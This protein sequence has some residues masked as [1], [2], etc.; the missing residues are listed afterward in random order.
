LKNVRSDTEAP[1][2]NVAG[3]LLIAVPSVVAAGLVI[4]AIPYYAGASTRIAS[5]Y[6]NVAGPADKALSP[7]INGYTFHRHHKLAAAKLDLS[8]EAKTEASF[9]Q[10]LAQITFPAAADPHADLLIAADKK[11][12]KLIGLQMQARTLRKLRSFDARDQAADVA[13]EVQV[14]I[15]RQDLGLPAASGPLY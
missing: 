11:R 3:F 12:I 5:L 4:L 14:R 13:V 8:Q 10:Q 1:R 2:R 9:D 7:E 15:I 6:A